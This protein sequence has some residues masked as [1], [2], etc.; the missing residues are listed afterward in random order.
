[1]PIS[2]ASRHLGV[3]SSGT[4]R[5]VFRIINLYKYMGVLFQRMLKYNLLW[6]ASLILLQDIPHRA[7]GRSWLSPTAELG[8]FGF[9]RWAGDDSDF[10]K[11]TVYRRKQYHY[12]VLLKMGIPLTSHQDKL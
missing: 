7:P 5:S 1:M 9:I 10:V 8:T 11:L 12:Q 2:R 4:D 3:G 6:K